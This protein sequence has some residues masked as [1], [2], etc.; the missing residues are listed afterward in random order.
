MVDLK[1]NSL[2]TDGKLPM[3]IKRPT[4]GDSSGGPVVMYLLSNAGDTGLIPGLGAKI[5]RVMRQLSPCAA[6]REAYT[7][8]LERSLHATAKTHESR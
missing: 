4:W 6:I 2:H 7:L 5:P 1:L 8:H 3:S